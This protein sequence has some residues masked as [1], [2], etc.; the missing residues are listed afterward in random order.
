M[1]NPNTADIRKFLTEFFSDEELTT[2]CFDYFRDVYEDFTRGMA[3]GQKIQ[4]LLDR[5][6]RRE[7]LPNLLAA[8]HAERTAQYEARFGAPAPVANLNQSSLIPH[9]IP[10]GLHHPRRTRT[11]S[12]PTAWQPTCAQTAGGS[13]SFRI[14]SWRARS[15]L[16]QSAAAWMHAASL[17]CCSRQ[18]PCGL[19]GSRPKLMSPSHWRTKG[20][21]DL[22]RPRLSGAMCRRCGL[23]T[24]SSRFGVT[25]KLAWRHSSRSWA[26]VAAVRQGRKRRARASSRRGQG[27][28]HPAKQPRSRLI[29]GHGPKPHSLTL[30]RYRR[31][32]VTRQ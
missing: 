7:A 15:G 8:L 26:R 25:T 13:G 3:K 6:V 20:R 10:T 31:E 23:R 32:P 28:R 14:A 2:L 17:S 1:A 24:S 4:L 21:R 12:S 16:R 5:C 30:F 22:S 9:A 19:D 11:P 18:P 29:R 27:A